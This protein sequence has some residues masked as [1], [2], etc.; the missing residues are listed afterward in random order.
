MHGWRR[1]A[2]AGPGRTSCCRPGGLI[3]T[4]DL[5]GRRLAVSVTRLGNV[6]K[7]ASSGGSLSGLLLG[8]VR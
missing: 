3:L 5:E 1:P 2:T 6:A 8:G 4:L 7:S